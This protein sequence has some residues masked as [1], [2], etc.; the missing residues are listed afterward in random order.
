MTSRKRTIV[1]VV[2][3]AVSC[4]AFSFTSGS[5][6]AHDD[7]CWTFITEGPR[8][9]GW[10]PSASRY[11]GTNR[12]ETA[13]C[14]SRIHW[15]SNSAHVIVLAR[16]DKFPDALAGAPLATWNHGLLLLTP[17]DELP[18][19]VMEEIKRVTQPGALVYLLG[20]TSSIS[21]DIQD[22][23]D[24]VGFETHRL[25]GK[26]RYETAVEVAK[27]LPGVSNFFFATGNN[28][29][30]AV[31]AG[32]AAASFNA[33]F[34]GYD[35]DVHPMAILL[36]N[37][38]AIEQHVVDFVNAHHDPA[39]PVGGMFTAGGPADRAAVNAFGASNLGGRFVGSNRFDTAVQ[40]AEHLL[41]FPPH[42]Q[43]VTL[44]TG[45]NFP[46]AL[47]ASATFGRWGAPLLLTRSTTPGAETLAYLESNDGDSHVM[48]VMGGASAISDAVVRQAHQ[49][50]VRDD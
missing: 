9:H 31:A 20:G 16:G 34:S 25:A 32:N 18:A 43:E 7:D 23:L 17:P 29:P 39:A 10:S 49:A 24:D 33:V 15:T 26:D 4:V 41:F 5:A 2:A 45:L 42:P 14:L 8:E 28:F 11:A 46:D 6:A 50:W 27:E 13:I 12:Y 47:A 19:M 30:D 35:P 38:D 44:A 21:N 36:T 37:D 48:T 40:I 1:G 3:A 22:E